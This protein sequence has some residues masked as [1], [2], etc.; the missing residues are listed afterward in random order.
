MAAQS[1]DYFLPN[2]VE[3]IMLGLIMDQPLLISSLL[4]HAARNHSDAEIVSR[5]IEGGIHR[6]T[7]R[8]AEVRAKKLAQ[9]LQ[10][11]GVETSDRIG[12]LAWNGYRHFELYY[13]TSGSG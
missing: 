8:D 3:D 12:S 4:T 1:A 6:Y 2:T 13:A 7:Y 10:R 11:L 9:A 5:T